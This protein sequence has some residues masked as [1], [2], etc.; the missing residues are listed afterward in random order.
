MQVLGGDFGL[1]AIL[2]QCCFSTSAPNNSPEQVTDNRKR[3]S[4]LYSAIVS[5]AACT[6][7]DQRLFESYAR[8]SPNPATSLQLGYGLVYN[9]ATH[10]SIYYSLDTTMSMFTAPRV[11]PLF[12]RLEPAAVAERPVART[13]RAAISGALNTEE[14]ATRH[15]AWLCGALGAANTLADMY[16]V[17]D[18]AFPGYLTICLSTIEQTLW[19]FESVRLCD[20]TMERLTSAAE[21]EMS[22][23][24]N[25][26]SS[27]QL[28]ELHQLLQGVWDGPENHVK[29]V[30]TRIEA[31]VGT[32]HSSTPLPHATPLF[33]LSYFHSV[34]SHFPR[35]TSP[36]EDDEMPHPLILA[37]H[38]YRAMFVLHFLF[39]EFTKC[40]RDADADN[41]RMRVPRN[42]FKTVGALAAREDGV[43]L[44]T[45]V[46]PAFCIE[47]ATFV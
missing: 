36:P 18:C 1:L 10:E 41:N 23:I 45:G 22:I 32:T 38:N 4:H 39:Q 13:L 43:F 30:P 2:E 9:P 24:T 21:K 34:P 11:P 25:Q 5:S 46:L 47:I 15:H 7:R 3:L 29:Y 33:A 40:W 42:I 26:F 20:L 27:E 8:K 14:L 16:Y 44:Q 31:D 37:S 12:M 28:R 35:I 6:P 17:V 19:A